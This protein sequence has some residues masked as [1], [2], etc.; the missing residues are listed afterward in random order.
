IAVT[1]DGRGLDRAR[2]RQEARARGVPESAEDRELLALVFHPGL[3]TARA[4][5]AVSGR[6]VGLDVVKSQVNALHGTVGLES[7]AG[8]GTTFALTVPLTVTLIR[9]LLVEW[10]GRSSARATTQVIGLRRLVPAEV[11]TVGSR[12]MLAAPA[13]LLPLLSLA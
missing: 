4:L 1:D 5:T 2:I 12:E 3:S 13:G 10:A 6:G 8:A 11:R 9:A 7:V